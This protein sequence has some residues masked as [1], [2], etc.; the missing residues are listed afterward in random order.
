[1]FVEKSEIEYSGHVSQG[2]VG[3]QATMDLLEA[4]NAE[5]EKEGPTAFDSRPAA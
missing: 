2:E 1:M 4:L 3:M 5:R